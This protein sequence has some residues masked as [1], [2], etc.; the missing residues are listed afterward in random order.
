MKILPSLFFLLVTFQV[1]G[2]NKTDRLAS[3][4][5]YGQYI[6]APLNGSHGY[7]YKDEFAGLKDDYILWFY[8]QI[9]TTGKII[10]LHEKHKPNVPKLVVDYVYKLINITNGQWTPEVKNHRLVISDTITCQV[11]IIKRKTLDDFKDEK[12]EL[13]DLDGYITDI[14]NRKNTCS[15]ILGYK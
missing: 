12:L 6:Q 5:N 15:L 11:H 14:E 1:S 8:F 4:K 3:Y 13:M 7:N 9:D 2:Q 10:N